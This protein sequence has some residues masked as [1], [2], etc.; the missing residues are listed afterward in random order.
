MTKWFVLAA[1]VF[2]LFNGM[3][4][5][6]Y[7]YKNRGRYCWQMDCINLYSCFANP[8]G[9]YVVVWARRRAHSRVHLARPA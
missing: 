5:R 6:T 8:A 2:L 4:A 7:G 9:P 3:L 1:G